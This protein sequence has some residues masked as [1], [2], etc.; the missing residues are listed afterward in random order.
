MAL[1]RNRDFIDGADE[2]IARREARRVTLV[3]VLASFVIGIGLLSILMYGRILTDD[4]GVV[5]TSPASLVAS[6]EPK[7]NTR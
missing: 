3:G 4:V 6:G 1:D 5:S 2:A 7:P